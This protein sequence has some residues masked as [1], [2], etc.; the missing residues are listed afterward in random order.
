MPPLVQS[1]MAR[2]QLSESYKGHTILRTFSRWLGQAEMAG[3][4]NMGD[5]EM[6]VDI[7][8][9]DGTGTTTGRRAVRPGPNVRA[10]NQNRKR[11]LFS[12]L[13]LV[14]WRDLRTSAMAAVAE[15]MCSETAQGMSP[16][17]SAIDVEVMG[18]TPG[19]VRVAG[20]MDPGPGLLIMN[21][22]RAVTQGPLVTAVSQRRIE[23][24]VIQIVRGKLVTG[25]RSSIP[26]TVANRRRKSR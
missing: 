18:I 23:I 2:I 25:H 7:E 8:V 9:V 19:T 12:M 22:R 10:L 6:M 3:V 21:G 14:M 11:Y 24:R 26:G 5:R 15:D 1:F 17:V 13:Q 20:F 4:A 16:K